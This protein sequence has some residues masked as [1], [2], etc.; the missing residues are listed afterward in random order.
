[1]TYTRGQFAVMGNVGR[2]ALRLYHEEG[3]LVPVSINEENGY[4]YYDDTQLET[5][6][7]IKR[8]R[9]IG[10]SLFEIRQ[11][12][13]GMVQE[14]EIVD[15]KIRETDERLKEMKALAGETEK[16]ENAFEGK[17][18]I[19]PFEKTKCIYIEENV[20]L[21]NLGMS[22][23]KL[24]E[25]VAREGMNAEDSHFVRYE[26]LLDDGQ[27]R[28]ITCLPVSQYA[29][30]DTMDIRESNCLHLNYPG[31]FSKVSEAHRIIR[32]YAEEQGIKLT[33][34]VYEV[35]NKDMTVD[36]YYTIE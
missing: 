32:K 31:G 4:H 6:E 34:R 11:I 28:M 29:G 9:K 3:L 10:L 17:P 25:R 21:D 36:V 23:G 26:G 33:D 14:E 5:L 22:V 7:K 19:Q 13:D 20:E 2:K 18:D 30:K 24:Y 12:L 16:K 1:M 15:S 27:F 8:L 35:Y